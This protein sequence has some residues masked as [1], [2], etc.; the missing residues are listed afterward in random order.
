MIAPDIIF[1][2][3]EIYLTGDEIYLISSHFI[4]KH[5]LSELEILVH[6]NI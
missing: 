4:R 1:S 6:Q 3:D 5:G 2:G